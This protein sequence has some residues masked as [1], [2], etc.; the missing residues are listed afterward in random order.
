[1]VLAFAYLAVR[2]S[3]LFL[4]DALFF[5]DALFAHM[6]MILCPL[7]FIEV[8]L[9]FAYVALEACSWFRTGVACEFSVHG[10]DGSLVV[11][12][13][14]A[15]IALFQLLVSKGWRNASTA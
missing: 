15:L 11:R 7:V 8:V 5:S 10:D 6:P 9:A 14:W 1:M 4:V 2:A 13:L 3:S 12:V